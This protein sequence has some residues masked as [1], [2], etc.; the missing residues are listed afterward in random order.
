MFHVCF[1]LR[2]IKE[3]SINLS[4]SG[5]CFIRGQRSGVIKRALLIIKTH[6]VDLNVR[7]KEE[8]VMIN[9]YVFNRDVARSRG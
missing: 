4:R 9:R 8:N 3:A 1:L 6:E 2:H 7:Y 5:V